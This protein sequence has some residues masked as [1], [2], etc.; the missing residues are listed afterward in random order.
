MDQSELLNL[1]AGIGTLTYCIGTLTYCIMVHGNLHLK[2]KFCIYTNK[3]TPPNKLTPLP[4]KY[5]GDPLVLWL[6]CSFMIIW[7]RNVLPK[8]E[9]FLFEVT[10]WYIIHYTLTNKLTVFIKM[11]AIIK[12]FV[13]YLGIIFY[14]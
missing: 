3:L 11:F 14:F 13:P 7:P 2:V 10:L 5:C 9:F 1:W 12:F 6:C 8:G 4:S